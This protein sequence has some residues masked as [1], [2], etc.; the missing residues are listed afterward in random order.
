MMYVTDPIV[1]SI[2]LFLGLNFAVV[3]AFFILVPVV[4]NLTYNADLQTIG[5]AFLSAIGG[6]VLSAITTTLIDTFTRPKKLQKSENTG[7]INPEYRLI[8]AM[9]GAPMITAT[10]FWIGFTSKP[11]FVI[12]V[13]VVATGFY[14]WSNQTTLVSFLLSDG[15]DL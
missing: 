5:L 11:T 14:V 1:A 15:S 7:M 3:F 12:Q 6:A 4:L 2:S 9:L 10:L 8:P 13:P